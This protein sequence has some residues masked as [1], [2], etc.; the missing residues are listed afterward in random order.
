MWARSLHRRLLRFLPVE[1]REHHGDEISLVFD[2]LL[3][4]ARARGRFAAF[5]VAVR[6]IATLLRFCWRERQATPD[7]VLHMAQLEGRRPMFGPL[8]QDLRHA[9]RL[10]RRSPGFTCVALLTMGLAVGANT[11]VFSVVNAVLLR[12]LPFTDPD[13]VVVLGHRTNGGD[14]LDSTTPGNLHD[15]MHDATA[16]SAMAGFSSTE[17]IVMAN[18]QAERIRGGI[19]VGSIFAV[20]GRDAALGRTLTA[21]DDDA[22]ADPVVVLSA[23]L[24]RRLFGEATAIGQSLHINSIA[25]TVVGVMPADFAFFDYDYEYWIPAR[26]D[27][28]FRVNRD[29]YFLLGIAR[30]RPDT[31]VT[32]AHAQLNT[33]M[34]GIRQAYPQFTQ[35]A[36]AAV[37]P[38][39]EVLLDGVGTR[40]LVLMGAVG[41]VLL[42]ACGNLAHLLLARATA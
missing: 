38:M 1:T 32:Q 34:D 20:L 35:N 28:A 4:D 10:L 7:D 5:R 6:E 36:T 27:A 30:L 42:I 19:S 2:E 18:G 15:W 41:F 37:L 9:A 12:T 17:R 23:R 24:A 25:Y 8:V 26:F 29:Q 21:H 39:K 14:S 11:A 16:F 13:G 40:L 22:A 33:V 31:T 3:R